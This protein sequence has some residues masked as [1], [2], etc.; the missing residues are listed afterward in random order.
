[1]GVTAVISARIRNFSAPTICA[2]TGISRTTLWRRR[3]NNNDAAQVAT[4]SPHP[5][6]GFT[7]EDVV[8]YM[9]QRRAEAGLAPL[10]EEAEAD[11]LNALVTIEDGAVA[12]RTDVPVKQHAA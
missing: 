10:S 6:G 11:I 2:I 3:R 12:A 7:G 5:D 9:Q 1:M 8:R 4:L